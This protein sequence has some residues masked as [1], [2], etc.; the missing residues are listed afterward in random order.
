MSR[1]KTGADPHPPTHTH[2][3]TQLPWDCCQTQLARGPQDT[4]GVT[5]QMQEASA[6]CPIHL[7]S[8]RHSGPVTIKGPT[9]QLPLGQ[10]GQRAWLGSLG[11]G[12]ERIYIRR[13]G[14]NL[15]GDPRDQEGLEGDRLGTGLRMGP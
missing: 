14:S 11:N 9:L 6:S 1:P 8:A 10:D 5:W 13:M 15:T 2:P 7:S 12:Q 4:R 3:P